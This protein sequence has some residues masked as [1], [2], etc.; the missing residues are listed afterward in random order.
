LTGEHVEHELL[1]QTVGHVH[2]INAE[3]TVQADLVSCTVCGGPPAIGV[4]VGGWTDEEG[5]AHYSS[6]LLTPEAALSIANTI[7]AAVGQA[8]A[9]INADQAVAEVTGGRD[10][11]TELAKLLES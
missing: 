4:L 2:A 6:A 11:D 1:A 7:L 9:A 3:I 5:T 10:W 8:F